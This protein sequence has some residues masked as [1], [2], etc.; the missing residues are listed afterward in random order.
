MNST[1]LD[2]ILAALSPQN[3]DEIEVYHKQGRSRTFRLGPRSETTSLQEE[4]GWAVRAGDRR[5]SFFFAASGPPTPDTP[6][7]EADGEG[8]RLPSAK[9]VT[10]WQAPSDLDLPLIGE[11]EAR[12]L[13]ESLR[14]ALD[15]E[16]P[17]ARLTL[18]ILEDGSSQSQ[19]VSSRDI[20]C[21]VRQRAASLLVEAVGAKG[22]RITQQLIGRDARRFS[23]SSFASRLADRLLVLERGAGAQRDRSEMLLAP[24]VVVALLAAL[25]PFWIGPKALE[26]TAPLVHRNGRIGC[27]Q[28]TLI[29]NGRLPGGLFEAPVDGEGQP[30]RSVTLVEEGIYRQPLL[31]WWQ[32]ATDRGQPSGCCR[33]ASWRDLPRPGVTHFYLRPDAKRSVASLLEDTIRGYYVL[34]IEGRPRIDFEAGRFA[35]PICGF[36]VAG[37]RATGSVKETWLTGTLSSFL[38]GILD[39]GRDLTFLPALGGL[40]G[41]P[42]LRV[43]GLELR[44][45]P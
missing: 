29:D 13:L 16:L 4:E 45:N 19:L 27:R 6:W 9:L 12:G 17:G 20:R 35:I 21:E 2:D 14:R 3:W 26:R 22:G 38:N 36:A 43:K 40:V 33:R 10:A 15:T 7:P 34:D 39:V 42:T 24:P 18:A 44:P 11:N 25:A 8:L 32:D 30:S 23:P 41:S 31:A 5:R 28:L 37:G 1:P